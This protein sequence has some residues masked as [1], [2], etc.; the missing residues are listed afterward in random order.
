MSEG[1]ARHGSIR[2]IEEACT[3]CMICVRECPAWCIHIASHT[4]TATDLP[5]GARD[6][7]RNELD[8]F[9]I[10]WSVCMYCG[11]CVDECPFD[12]LVWAGDHH[13]GAASIGGLLAGREELRSAGGSS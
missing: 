1:V 8:R 13:P 10:D 7:T 2:L 5:P 9:D 12:A 4:V 6:R 3:A 11:I